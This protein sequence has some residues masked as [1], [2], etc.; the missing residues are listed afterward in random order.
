MLILIFPFFIFF[1][2]FFFF[3]NKSKWEDDTEGDKNWRWSESPEPE[4]EHRSRNTVKRHYHSEERERDFRQRSARDKRHEQVDRDAVT[5]NDSPP[6]K[7]HRAKSRRYKDDEKMIDDD[8]PNDRESSKSSRHSKKHQGKREEGSDASPKRS[9]KRRLK[10]SERNHRSVSRRFSS[11]QSRREETESVDKE[12]YKLKS[13]NELSQE[14]RRYRTK[15]ARTKEICVDAINGKWDKENS[16]T[17]DSVG[18]ESSD[19]EI[20]DQK[21]IDESK[22]PCRE[23]SEKVS[24]N[25]WATTDSEDDALLRIAQKI[26]T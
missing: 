10:S 11:K 13:H 5:D 19:S 24:D 23:F 9:R 17:V 3:R 1:I 20:E 15:D 25:E 12:G 4:T 8:V 2:F 21:R 26:Q 7:R 14:P 18:T 16:E 22:T 6:V